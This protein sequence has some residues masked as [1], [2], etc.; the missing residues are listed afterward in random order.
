MFKT[1]KSIILSTIMPLSCCVIKN[2]TGL[3]PWVPEKGFCILEFPNSSVFVLHE[4]LRSHLSLCYEMRRLRMEASHQ[5]DQ[6]R[7]WCWDFKTGRPPGKGKNGKKGE[8][9]GCGELKIGFN[10][11]P[12]IQSI[13]PY[14]KEA[15][16]KTSGYQSSA[17]FPV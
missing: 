3:C 1:N 9:K 6:P 8:N 4:P 10:E 14:G 7:D 5:K 15:P 12:M 13:R 16:K 2:V 11:A 17:E